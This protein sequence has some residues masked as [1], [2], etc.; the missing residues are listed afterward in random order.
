MNFPNEFKDIVINYNNKN[1]NEALKLLN[2]LP[3]KEEFE[4]F[5]IKLYASIYFLTGKWIQ[6]LTYHNKIVEKN[7]ASFEDYNNLAVSL[8]NLGRITET[9]TYFKKC[10][11]INNKAELPYQNLGTSYLHLGNYEQAIDCFTNA[12][13][14]NNRNNNCKI[15]TIDIL[16]YI[17]PKTNQNNLLLKLNEKVLNN[18]SDEKLN[19]IPKYELIIQ[20]I[21]IIK[22][23]LGKEEHKI[24]YNKTEIFRR[25][26]ENLNCGRHFKVFN[27]FSVIPEYCFSC[28]K[29]QISTKNVF[30]LIKLFFLFNTNYLENNNV[31]K[32]MVETRSNVKENFKGFIYCRSLDEAKKILEISESK[33]IEN[34]IDYKK[35]EIKH[36]CT[37]YYEKHP[38]FKKINYNGE[39]EMSYEKSW[40]K[41]EKLVDDNSPPFS[42]RV[43]NP[44]INKINLSDILIIKNWLDYAE[45]VGDNSFEKIY[46]SNVSSN[47]LSQILKNQITFRKQ[48]F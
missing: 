3:K 34:E 33:L 26:T 21:D 41:Y 35:I 23:D 31:R 12:L 36:G 24:I 1:F 48:Q 11:E 29:V 5:K 39:Q 43:I 47:F 18:F 17:V 32:C 10:I 15:M 20:L 2:N 7:E 13:S 14:L 8:F 44:T 42:E 6:S 30:S 27:K 16:N 25:N 46:S 4:K 28:Y 9:I 22:D 45:I 19:K 40:K 38:N 37:E